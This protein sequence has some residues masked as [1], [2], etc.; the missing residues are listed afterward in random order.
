ML[1][2]ASATATTFGNE[3]QINVFIDENSFGYTH[4]VQANE[5]FNMKVRIVDENFIPL[6]HYHIDFKVEDKTGIL[7]KDYSKNEIHESAERILSDSNGFIYFTFPV[8][9][10]SAI[11]DNSCYDI[12]ET[13]TF[14]IIQNGLDRRERFS[15]TQQKLEHDWFGQ[16]LRWYLY[17]SDYLFIVGLIILVLFSTVITFLW[18]WKKRRK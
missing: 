4:T 15:V 13:Y 3:R 10:C 9:S 12:D 7:I 11:K 5:F 6:D 17:N 8:V 16:S 1:L 18:V 2:S 14:R